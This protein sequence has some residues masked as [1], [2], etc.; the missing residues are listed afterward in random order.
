MNT[1][2]AFILFNRPDRAA[3]VF[4]EIA[5]ARPSKLFLIADGPRPNV[6][7]D[8]EKCSAA[9]AVVERVNWDC[10]V[11]RNFSDEN[12]GC[13]QR[14]ATGIS[15][16]FKQVDRA[17]ILEDDCVPHPTFFRFCEDVLEHYRDD[18]RVMHV[19]GNN[20]QQG[21]RF[22]SASYFFSRHNICLGGWATWARAWRHY[23]IELKQWPALRDTPWLND[24]VGEP[25]STKGKNFRRSPR[26]RENGR[27]LGL[28]V[29]VQLLGG[30]RTRAKSNIGFRE[31]GTHTKQADDKWANVS[32]A[33]IEFPLRHPPHMTPDAAADRF[34]VE[35]TLVNRSLPPRNGFYRTLSRLRALRVPHPA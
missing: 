5:K 34:F 4:A 27:L 12:L 24:I 6:P 10:D 3:Q 23:D 20:F 26:A 30:K 7:E 29:D 2:V 25:D 22:G 19:A 21:R 32:T 16:V 17:I 1:S 13:G 11:Q 15:W 8:D 35:Q 18:E 31:D 33:P 28:S 9:R 14:P